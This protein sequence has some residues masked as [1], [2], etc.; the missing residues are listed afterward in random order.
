MVDIY[1]TL[2]NF[3]QSQGSDFSG[4]SYR[5]VLI[6]SWSRCLDWVF[7][8]ADLGNRLCLKMAC[9]SGEE[10]QVVCQDRGGFRPFELQ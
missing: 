2:D 7:Y 5:Q 3:S 1:F 9:P 8:R 6:P 4:K 10:T